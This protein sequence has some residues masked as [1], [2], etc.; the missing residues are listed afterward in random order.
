MSPAGF[1]LAIPTSERPQ[2]HAL[3]RAATGKGYEVCLAL[4][5]SGD[6]Q[7]L[8]LTILR[9]DCNVKELPDLSTVVQ[10]HSNKLYIRCM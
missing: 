7:R 4:I 6:L 8:K 10:T 5:K 3:D 1:E 9:N 2:T